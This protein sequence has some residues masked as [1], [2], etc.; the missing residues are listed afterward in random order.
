MSIP[1]CLV[2]ALCVLPA[3]LCASATNSSKAVHRAAGTAGS[4]GIQVCRWA[5]RN[6]Q[7]GFVLTAFRGDDTEKAVQDADTDTSIEQSTFRPVIPSDPANGFALGDKTKPLKVRIYPMYSKL[8]KGGECIV[9]VELEIKKGW[10]INANP[11]SPDFLV[12]TKVELKTKQKIKL[13]QVKY[14]KHHLLR[15]KG[16]PDPYHVY[17][18]KVL[19][20]G[21]IEIA[22]DE[23]A[24]HAE[25]EFHISFQGCNSSQCLPPDKIVMKVLKGKLP[26]AAPGE[27]LQKV[28][29]EKF[30]K[31]KPKPKGNQAPTATGIP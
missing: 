21:L 19:V 2:V 11:S 20:Y 27:K 3:E 31:P 28:H 23:A 25:F 9:A 18:G 30:P 1:V 8:P 24:S 12:P 4:P 13:K 10:H 22:A 26:L 16:S 17:D 6:Q 15:V 29:E 14:P 7:T 5:H